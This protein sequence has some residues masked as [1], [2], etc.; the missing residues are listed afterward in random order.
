MTSPATGILLIAEPFLRDPSFKRSVVLLCSHNE[1]EGTFGF[2]L[3]KILEVTFDRIIPEMAGWPAPV[4]EGGP[5]HPDTLHY[6]HPYPEHFPEAVK[7]T[8][9]VYWGGDFELMKEGIKNGKIDLKK[10][11][12]FLGYSGWS[13]GQLKNEMAENSWLT[14]GATKKIIFETHTAEIW[15]ASLIQLGGKY[16]MMIHYPTDPQLN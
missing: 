11:K 5:V 1:E 4:F 6:L 13:E 15:N 10:I 3:N 12:F 16:K 14:V 7:I 8:E 2:T 9:G